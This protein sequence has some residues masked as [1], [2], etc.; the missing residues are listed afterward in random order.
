MIES[1]S[2]APTRSYSA[3][4]MESTESPVNAHSAP[5]LNNQVD[6]LVLECS[7]E[8][9][10]ESD[11][12][13]NTSQTL[14]E[15]APYQCLA[16]ETENAPVSSII[17][18]ADDIQV[19]VT[20]AEKERIDIAAE[21]ARKQ[22]AESQATKEAEEKRNRASEHAKNAVQVEADRNAQATKRNKVMGAEDIRKREAAIRVTKKAENHRNIKHA[23]IV[24]P[25]KAER[26]AP[27]QPT[28]SYAL[29]SMR[30]PS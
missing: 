5:G 19:T 23:E 16:S 24:S 27:V 17:F 30:D 9:Q 12:T 3:N 13:E 1:R 14:L 29:N 10:I 15:S 4:S 28:V 11:S 21:A 8:H 6:I 2:I 7:P 22:E 25:I 26:K 18:A 20:Q